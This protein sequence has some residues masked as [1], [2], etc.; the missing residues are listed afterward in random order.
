MDVS[1]DP[2][3]V[4]G[5]ESND[6]RLI[7]AQ[8]SA[9]ISL[10]GVIDGLVVRRARKRLRAVRENENGDPRRGSDEWRGIGKRFFARPD[11]TV[12]APG[13]KIGGVAGELEIAFGLPCHRRICLQARAVE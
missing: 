8:E 9:A 5:R 10:D 4:F 13:E 11:A 2:F 6:E 7:V 1:A 3:A 12:N